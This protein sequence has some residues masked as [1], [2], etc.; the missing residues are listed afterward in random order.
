MLEN[1]QTVPGSWD[2][3]WSVLKPD[4]SAWFFKAH[5]PGDPVWPGSLGLEACLQ[6][7]GYLAVR[8]FHGGPPSSFKGTF[9]SPLPGRKHSWLYR[10]QIPPWSMPVD[11]GI[12]VTK[13]DPEASSVTFNAILWRSG[14]VIYQL[15]DFTASLA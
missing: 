7:A 15:L 12:M 9:S 4:P 6:A 14:S 1:L 5:F 3:A 13:A 11:L 8:T 10:G 2:R